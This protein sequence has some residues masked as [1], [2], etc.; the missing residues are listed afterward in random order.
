MVGAMIVRIEHG[1]ITYTTDEQKPARSLARI[2]QTTT[3][4]ASHIRPASP[5][6]RALFHALRVLGDHSPLAS[7][8]RLIPG[9]WTADMQP[10][11]GPHLGTYATRRNALNAERHWL[12]RHLSR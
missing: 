2:G 6:L 8:S 10:I 7:L 4:R 11:D 12:D 3:S 9:R 5:A 1:Q